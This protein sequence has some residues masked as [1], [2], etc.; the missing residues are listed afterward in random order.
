MFKKLLLMAMVLSLAVVGPSAVLAGNGAGTAGEG[1]MEANGN[2][3]GPRQ[4]EVRSQA[5]VQANAE[6]GEAGGLMQATRRGLQKMQR[7]GEPAR[8]EWQALKDNLARLKQQYRLE[9]REENRAEIRAMFKLAVQMAKEQGE[10]EEM[11]NLLRDL[12]SLAPGDPEPY[13]ELGNIYRNR[14]EKTPKVFCDGNELKPDVP[15]VIKEGRT[16]IPIR[17]ITEALGATVQ[18]N[19]R[20]RTVLISK[21]DTTIQLQVENRV[22]LVNGRR[23]ELDVPAENINSRVFVPLRFISEALKA[24]VGFYPEGQIVTVNQEAVQAQS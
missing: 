3:G 12:I 7:T 19:E 24:Q 2:A 18:W 1:R 22:A 9:T 13:R 10:P 21:G 14:G 23:V 11:E 20:E 16:L 4:L 6:A 5:G 15:P 17:P 8:E